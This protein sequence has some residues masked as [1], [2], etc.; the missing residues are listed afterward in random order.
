VSST[1]TTK[2]KGLGFINNSEHFRIIDER[3][4]FDIDNKYRL[5]DVT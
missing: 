5:F 3:T 1:I 4:I 2:V